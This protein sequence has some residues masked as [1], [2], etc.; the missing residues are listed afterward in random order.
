MMTQKNKLLQGLDRTDALCF[1]GNRAT[2]EWIQKIFSSLKSCQ[3]EGATYWF[4]NDRPSVANTRIKQYPTGHTAFY[5]PDG[6]RFLTVD[7]DGHP[8]NEAEWT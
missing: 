6:R 7:P 2:G 3:S 8:L 5:R 1:P 4:E